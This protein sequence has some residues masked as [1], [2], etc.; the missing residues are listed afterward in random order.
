MLRTPYFNQETAMPPSYRGSR[1]LLNVA[2]VVGV[3]GIG[4]SLLL[5][6]VDRARNAARQSSVI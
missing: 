3:V 5:P 6:A 2:V 4:A 1:A